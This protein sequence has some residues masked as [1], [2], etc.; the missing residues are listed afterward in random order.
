M[1][2]SAPLF[3][4]PGTVVPG[5]LEHVL[6]RRVVY[7]RG[8]LEMLGT[9]IASHGQ[10]A[11]LVSYA[12]GRTTRAGGPAQAA[13]S[14]DEARVRITHCAVQ[15]PI[16]TETV[17]AIVAACMAAHCDVV[18]AIGGGGPIDAAKVAAMIVTN[19]GR[20]DDYHRGRVISTSPLP[21]VAIPT[22][23]GTG[24][25]ATRVGV[26][27]NDALGVVKSIGHPDMVPVAC[28]LDPS[29]L[30]SLPRDRAV[31]GAFDGLAHAIEACVS[32]GASPLTTA[33]A[34]DATRVIARGL[35]QA[36][37]GLTA[38]ALD[39]LMV[40]SHLAG[41]ALTAGPGLAHVLAQP[42]TAVTGLAHADVIAALLPTTVA[43]NEEAM[44]DRSRH[45][46]ALISPDGPV[47][48][49]AALQDMRARLGMKTT[50]ARLGVRHDQ[51]AAIVDAVEQSA[52]HIWTNPAPLT[53]ATVQEVLEVAWATAPQAQP[54][55][56]EIA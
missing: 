1:V 5:S 53:L 16:T 31:I 32:R 24:A 40:G 56:I 42:I 36:H 8:R 27:R 47:R 10:H 34:L 55:G 3:Q 46:A 18:V 13:Q 6:P 45:L 12:P 19:G 23:V 14:L 21:F 9:I 39:D 41:I 43:F 51:L 20:T 28:I 29:L 26:V 50:L 48:L 7:G 25:E 35:V 33:L 52:G 11:L 54:G 30:A 37:D 38:E 49:S 15:A 17:D 44:G 22:T 4:P 2:I